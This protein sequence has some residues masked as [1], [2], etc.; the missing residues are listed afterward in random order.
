MTKLLDRI[1]ETGIDGARESYGDRDDDKDRA[2]LMGSLE[3]FEQCRGKTPREIH[4]LY[5]EANT[6]RAKLYGWGDL[7]A[8]WRAVGA[9]N[10]IEWVANCLSVIAI[11]E[12]KDPLMAW[13]PTARALIHV[14]RLVIESIVESATSGP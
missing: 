3:G 14:D 10:E 1:I 11:S 9:V 2:L 6:K 12:G 13:L 4:E 8:Y 5:C 7:A